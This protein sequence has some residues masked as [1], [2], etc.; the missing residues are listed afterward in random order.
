MMGFLPEMGAAAPIGC[1]YRI[2]EYQDYQASVFPS[3]GLLIVIA[4][5]IPIRNLT[6]IADWKKELGG[7][8]SEER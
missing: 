4:H 3:S 2:P 1:T 8:V 7:S 6:L 5:S